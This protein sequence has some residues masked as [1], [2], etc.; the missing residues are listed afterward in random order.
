M[1]EYHLAIKK[2]E[3]FIYATVWMSLKNM[4]LS[5]R[6]QVGMVAHEDQ[7]LEAILSY[8]MRTC[9]KK[10]KH[11]HKQKSQQQQQNKE[12]RCKNPNML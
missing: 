10:P 11:K 9:L 8:I 6:R 1:V 3:I 7:D 4:M 5:E 2:N 12:D